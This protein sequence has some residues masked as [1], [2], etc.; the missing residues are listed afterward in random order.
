M[1]PNE[2]GIYLHDTPSKSLFGSEQRWVSNGCVR[3]EDAERVARWIFGGQPRPTH[4]DREDHLQL[5]EPMPVYITYLTAAP[6]GTATL[7]RADPYARDAKV[8]A[9]FADQAPAMR[10]ARP[11]L[12]I[13]FD[14]TPQGSLTREGNKT[15][16][17]KQNGSKPRGASPT[18]RKVASSGASRS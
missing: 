16:P 1:M 3:L 9:R 8:L 4:P 11:P 7:F 2:Y 12:T 14:A 10:D 18:T 5:Y 15:V 17:L 13:D 6:D